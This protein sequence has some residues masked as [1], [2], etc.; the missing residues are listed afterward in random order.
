MRAGSSSWRS[1]PCPGRVCPPTGI[2]R[3]PSHRRTTRCRGWPSASA[4]SEAPC[5][6]PRL[7]RDAVLPTRGVALYTIPAMNCCRGSD[8]LPNLDGTRRGGGAWGRCWELFPKL[9]LQQLK[10]THL[11]PLGHGLWPHLLYRGYAEHLEGGLPKKQAG[12]EGGEEERWVGVLGREL[13]GG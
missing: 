13:T 1:T 12:G 5:P 8:L 11:C 7:P 4:S 6:H 10:R 2:S 3:G 9:I